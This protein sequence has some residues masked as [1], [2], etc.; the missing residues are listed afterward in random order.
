MARR[1]IK[2]MVMP[3]RDM[4]FIMRMILHQSF[5][6]S[7]LGGAELDGR[8]N[9][10]T[11][12]ALT[13]VSAYVRQRRSPDASRSADA[14]FPGYFETWPSRDHRT[15]GEMTK[16]RSGCLRCRSLRFCA[17]VAAL[18]RSI[19]RSPGRR[20]KIGARGHYVRPVQEQVGKF[21]QK[22]SSLRRIKLEKRIEQCIYLLFHVFAVGRLVTAA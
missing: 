11:A 8:R 13:Y 18:S 22:E 3:M 15:P 1:P 17:S 14:D 6:R 20:T 4:N 7:N 21:V 10:A 16:R 9:T 12:N 5:R 19:D 2:T